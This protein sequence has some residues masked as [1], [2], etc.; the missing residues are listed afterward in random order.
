VLYLVEIRLRPGECA[1]YTILG[2]QKNGAIVLLVQ[3]GNIEFQWDAYDPAS[4]ATVKRGNSMMTLGTILPGT[5]QPF[6][7]G[8]WISIDRQV[9]FTY[10]NAGADTAIIA[11]AVWAPH[12]GGGCHGGCR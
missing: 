2:N 12:G 1:P 7:P 3:Q 9:W 4:T 10:R 6:Y 11:K 8:D 5:P